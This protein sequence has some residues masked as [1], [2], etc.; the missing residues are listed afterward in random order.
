MPALGYDSVLGTG[1]STATTAGGGA[2]ALGGL[3]AALGPIGLGLSLAG[4]FMGKKKVNAPPPRS[5]LGEMRGAVGAQRDV[6]P[7]VVS[8]DYDASMA[9]QNLQRQTLMGQLG[10]MGDLYG[11]YTPAAAGISGMNL[12]AFAP[13]YGRAAGYSADALRQGIGAGGMGLLDMMTAQAGEGLAAGG[14]LT[15]GELNFAQQSARQAA[16]ARGMNSS[17]WAA[18][19]EVLN[20]YKVRQAREDRAR[21]YAA[22]VYGMNQG[23]AGLGAQLFGNQYLGL[24]SATSPTS[25]LGQSMQFQGAQGPQFM[26]PESG[27]NANV[28]GS[29]QNATLQTALA[30]AQI[31]A[32]IG[33]GLMS[34]GGQI[35]G[36]YAQGRGQAGLPLFG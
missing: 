10:I 29:N 2:A 17:P 12:D 3:G 21:S 23:L 28:M 15:P 36:G 8:G 35:F 5:Y 1:I 30:N 16:A 9:Y 33:S 34:A 27:Y 18:A 7:D 20:S 6:L 26:Q 11:A 22:S 31:R 13:I 32:G 24:A 4:M 25:L 14:D 19:S